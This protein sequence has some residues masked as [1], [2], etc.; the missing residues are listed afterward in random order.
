[1]QFSTKFS[2]LSFS[3]VAALT[4]VAAGTPAKRAADVAGDA[5]LVARYVVTEDQFLNWLAT[6][7]AN[8]T[9]IGDPIDTTGISRRAAASTM[10]TYCS[11]RVVDVCGGACTVY[12][13]GAACLAAP[14]TQCLAATNNVGFCDRGGCTGSC[15]QLASCGTRLDDGFCATPGTASILVGNA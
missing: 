6:T 13:G 8:L 9:F 10:V 15:N 7:D 14:D 4:L 3:V 1:M 11:S 12:N 2:A 5:S